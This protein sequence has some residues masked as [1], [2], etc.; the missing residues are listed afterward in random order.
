MKGSQGRKLS[1][2]AV[3]SEVNGDNKDEDEEVKGIKKN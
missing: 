1:F 3:P 2:I